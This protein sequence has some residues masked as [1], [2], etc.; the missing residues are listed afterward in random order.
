M[1]GCPK[2]TIALSLL[3]RLPFWL[4]FYNP[5][6]YTHTLIKLTWLLF[7]QHSVYFLCVHVFVYN[8][9]TWNAFL[10]FFVIR[11][12]WPESLLEIS[13]LS[14]NNRSNEYTIIIGNFPNS[15]MCYG[16]ST[17]VYFLASDYKLLGA[18]MYF[19]V[20]VYFSK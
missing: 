3:P 12:H 5:S 1:E 19:T 17:Y 6:M 10:Y 7:L 9:P 14:K 16:Y 8:I 15:D 2:E 13:A 11:I 18:G 20:K 4:S